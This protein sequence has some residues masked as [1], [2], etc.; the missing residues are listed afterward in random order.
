MFSVFAYVVNYYV[1]IDDL[2]VHVCLGW[3]VAFS[4]AD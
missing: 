2:D 1:Y 4:L 3:W